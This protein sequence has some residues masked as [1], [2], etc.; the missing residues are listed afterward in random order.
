MKTDYIYDIPEGKELDELVAEKVMGW[1]KGNYIFPDGKTIGENDNDWLDEDGK[2]MCGIDKEDY[3]E[4]DEDFHLLH[5]HPSGSILWAWEI[6]EKS[7]SFELTNYQTYE[8][9]EWH[10]SIS[11]GSYCYDAKAETAPLAICRAALLAALYIA[12]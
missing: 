3:Y 6:V 2:F 1:H 10:C 7:K 9:N 11:L 8:P 12:E 4:D 5:W